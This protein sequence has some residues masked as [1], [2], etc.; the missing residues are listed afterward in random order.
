MFTVSADDEAAIRAAYTR[1]GFGP[2]VAEFRS[3]FRG[4]TN[5]H[6]AGCVRRIL[7]WPDADHPG[8]GTFPR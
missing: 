5:E 6:A 2:A 1:G 4:L 8:G 7:S 3:R